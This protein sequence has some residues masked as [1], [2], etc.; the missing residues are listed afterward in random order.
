MDS[1][2]ILSMLNNEPIPCGD[3]DFCLK[4]YQFVNYLWSINIWIVHIIALAKLLQHKGVSLTIYLTTCYPGEQIFYCI[5][6][7]FIVFNV[8]FFKS[9]DYHDCSKTL[10][11]HI[12]FLTCQCLG[13]YLF[14]EI[15]INAHY[16]L[17]ALENQQEN[18]EEDQLKML[19]RLSM[20]GG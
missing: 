5:S 1:I 15:F 3:H 2:S 11:G 10:T 14:A 4:T 16:R 9:I 20:L 12:T 19:H 18:M 8:I 7:W 6:Y 17:D 13:G